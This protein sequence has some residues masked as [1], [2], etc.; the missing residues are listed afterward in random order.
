[1]KEICE[2]S[3]ALLS[4]AQRNQSSLI[5]GSHRDCVNSG[6]PP[7]SIRR[8][9]SPLTI[10]NQAPVNCASL[11]RVS[12]QLL[13]PDRHI[14]MTFSAQPSPVSHSARPSGEDRQ[15]LA[16][17]RFTVPILQPSI[18]LSLI[19]TPLKGCVSDMIGHIKYQN[20]LIVIGARDSV[21]ISAFYS[22]EWV[23]S[24]VTNA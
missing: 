6:S 22:V 18:I 11:E 8:M 20:S 13:R 15:G 14:W 1:M 23:I 5:S 3:G 9:P 16:I 24:D 19:I 10:S 17:T 2:I 4:E 21:A 12:V 7:L